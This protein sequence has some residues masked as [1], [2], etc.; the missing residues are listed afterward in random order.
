[1]TYLNFV[2]A[3]DYFIIDAKGIEVSLTALN[4][5]ALAAAQVLAVGG[6]LGLADQIEFTSA[7]FLFHDGPIGIVLAHGSLNFKPGWEF[8]EETDIFA[9][10]EAE[11][12]SFL[13]LGVE[14]NH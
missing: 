11:S 5:L 12:E 4:L 13:S 1:M 7:V 2:V 8:E 10:I 3:G 14:F 6:T 9:G